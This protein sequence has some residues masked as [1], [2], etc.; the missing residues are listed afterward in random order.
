MLL[1]TGV[2]V[3]FGEQG[4]GYGGYVRKR[5]SRVLATL[6]LDLGAGYTSGFTL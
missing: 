2:L 1:V 6:F 4:F 3:T 5:A